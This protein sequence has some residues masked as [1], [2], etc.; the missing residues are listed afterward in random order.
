MIKMV[1]QLVAFSMVKMVRRIALE[2]QDKKAKS[3][4]PFQPSNNLGDW[5]GAAK[6][7]L[8]LLTQFAKWAPYKYD[9]KKK[10]KQRKKYGD[11]SNDVTKAGGARAGTWVLALELAGKIAIEYKSFWVGGVRWGV[12]Y[13]FHR[14]RPRWI[15]FMRPNYTCLAIRINQGM[16]GILFSVCVTHSMRED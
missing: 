3:L 1:D 8:C 11:V 13:I 7:K 14:F 9:N 6:C 15:W 10:R 12:S 4:L 16:R 5:C 2:L